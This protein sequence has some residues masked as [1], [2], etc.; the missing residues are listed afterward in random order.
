VIVTAEPNEIQDTD[1]NDLPNPSE[2][3]FT[4]SAGDFVPPTLI[5][6]A[7]ESNIG[8]TDFGDVGDSF[9]MVFSEVMSPTPFG[10]IVVQDGDG[11]GAFLSCGTVIQCTWNTAGTTVTV[12]V[13]SLVAASPGATFGLQ[14]PVTITT[15]NGFFD[16]Q[17]NQ[18][19]LPGSP[20]RVIDNEVVTGP[21]APP[22]VTDARVVNNVATT[23]FADTGDAFSLTFS[24]GMNLNP[25]GTMVLKDQD[26]S[27]A[28]VNCGSNAI[29]NWNTVVTELTIIVIMPLPAL[30][31]TTPGLQLPLRVVMLAGIA[32]GTNGMV[33]DLAGSPDTLI[34]YE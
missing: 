16:L 7:L 13:T 18:P 9:N 21:F 23:D 32:S 34:D 4:T 10:G 1:G 2:V 25:S 33:P 19:N 30:A 15:L 5:D 6:T 8:T 20:D 11:S 14:L 3:T 17:G 31:G 22:T 27:I 24:G 29:C 12:T 26:G 28:F